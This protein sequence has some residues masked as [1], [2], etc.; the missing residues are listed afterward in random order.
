[1]EEIAQSINKLDKETQDKT[2]T[3]INNNAKNDEQKK[4]Q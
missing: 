3:I 4:S 1:M 2:L